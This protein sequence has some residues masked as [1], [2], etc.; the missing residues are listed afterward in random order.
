[1]KSLPYSILILGVLTLN[2]CTP[3]SPETALQNRLDQSIDLIEAGDYEELLVN[4]YLPKLVKDLKEQHNIKRLAKYYGE[5]PQTHQ[6]LQDLK[7][8]SHIQPNFNAQ[9]TEAVFYHDELSFRMVW[10]RVDDV[11]YLVK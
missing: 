5:A 9:K 1:M 10:K 11:W 2:A 8:A 3:T 6:L 4:Y 7:I